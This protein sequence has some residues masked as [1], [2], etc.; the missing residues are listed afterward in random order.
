[1]EH[2]N[3]SAAQA[4]DLPDEIRIKLADN[5]RWVGYTQAQKVLKK[6]DYLFTCTPTHRPPCLLLVGDTG[7]G[8][9]VLLERY[10][11]SHPE[12]E[13]PEDGRLVRPVLYMQAPHTP[14]EKS[15]YAGILEAIGAPYPAN[16]HIINRQWRV[17]HLLKTVKVKVL[18]IDE[19]H[20]ILSGTQKTHRNFLAVLRFLTNELRI[21]L[22]GAGIRTAQNAVGYDPQLSS[23][24]EKVYLPRWQMGTEYL[25]LLASFERML[26][27]R[28]PSNLI[29]TSIAEELINRS[30]GTLGHLTILLRRAAMAA[31]EN[32]SE[33]IS[34]ELL[35][36]VDYSPESVD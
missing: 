35:K 17:I 3:S 27:L 19:I 22:V 33:Y 9:T 4:L 12:Y 23:R 7:N 21:P 14:D 13:Q 29:Q 6:L 16:E 34:L 2:L 36:E 30:K 1:M 15:F 24:F 10:C 18:V 28:R 20:N 5:A 31:I 26:P 8:K 25:R 32:K 11:Q